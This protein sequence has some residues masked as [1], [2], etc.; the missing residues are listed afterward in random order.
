MH[1]DATERLARLRADIDAL[2]EL[3]K[4]RGWRVLLD[5]AD[6]EIKMAFRHFVSN[7]V[8]A[9]QHLH[10]QRGA[11]FAAFQMQDMPTQLSA[12]LL[13]EHE[14]LKSTARAPEPEKNDA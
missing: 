2:N 1:M 3:Q 11:I 9:D 6:D 4:S 12:R 8:A 10:F 7:P 14:I 5:H 13:A